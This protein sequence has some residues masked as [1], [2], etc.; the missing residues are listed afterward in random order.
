MA[1]SFVAA[2]IGPE[3]RAADLDDQTSGIQMPFTANGETFTTTDPDTAT[4]MTDDFTMSDDSPADLGDEWA[5]AR[6]TRATTADDEMTAMTNE[7]IMDTVVVY[8]DIDDPTEAAY[9]TYFEMADRGG[10]S[11]PAAATG[12]LQ[13][14]ETTVGA[15]SERFVTADFGITDAHQTVPHPTPDDPDTTDVTEDS[16]EIMSSFYGIPGTFTCE[17][18]SC[19]ALSDMDGTISGLGGSWTFTPTLDD[20]DANDAMELME[21]M[22]AGVVPDPLYITMGYWLRDDYTGMMGARSYAASAFAHANVEGYTGIFSNVVGSATYEGSATGLY[23]DKRFETDGA[24]VETIP[25]SAG[26]FTA[27]VILN[28]NFGGTGLADDD[29]FRVTRT[30][31]SFVDAE[32]NNLYDWAVDLM[33]PGDDNSDANITEADGSFSGVTDEGGG[34]G[35]WSGQFY[36]SDD[37]TTSDVTEQPAAAAGTFDAHFT[38]GHVLGAFGAD[39]VE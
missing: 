6:Y 7:S 14:D 29:Q 12:V 39:L 24:S 4:D 26:Q 18:D 21:I 27:D 22:V 1:V 5:G 16:V 3:G 13:L 20:D 28:A 2:A 19:T 10:V 35:T 15:N 25:I 37:T 17:G 9:S 33:L 34:A 8:T 38:N 11:G 23:M 30:V 32:G 31:D 36:G